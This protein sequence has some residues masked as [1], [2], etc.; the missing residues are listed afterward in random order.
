MADTE[1]Q[2]SSIRIPHDLK[3][4][5]IR[6]A[7]AEGRTFSQHVIFLLEKYVES[8]PEPKSKSRKA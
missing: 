1:I 3:E 2:P 6:R 5:V 4:A 7:K 8:T